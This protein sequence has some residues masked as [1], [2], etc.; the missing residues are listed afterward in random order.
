MVYKR[1]PPLMFHHNAVTMPP[2]IEKTL[3]F[4]PRLIVSCSASCESARARLA[5]RRQ[6]ATCFARLALSW[7]SYRF[8]SSRTCGRCSVATWAA[9]PHSCDQTLVPMSV[10]G[11]RFTPCTGCSKLW[12]SYCMRALIQGVKDT[13]STLSPSTRPQ[14]TLKKD[15][16]PTT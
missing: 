16:P 6:Y 14:Q 2:I 7:R 1:I 3:P 8:E 15:A 12:R 5:S 11:R 4:K 13:P 9:Q 10:K